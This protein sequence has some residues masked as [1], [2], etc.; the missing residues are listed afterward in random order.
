MNI[1]ASLEH[2]SKTG[3]NDANLISRH[4][5]LNEM[6][7]SM[8]PKSNNRKLGQDHIAKK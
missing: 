6:A 1:T 2:L 8:E 4:H 7:Q 5:N 3:N